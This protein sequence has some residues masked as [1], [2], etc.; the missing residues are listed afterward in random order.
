MALRRASSFTRAPIISELRAAGGA[1]AQSG[2]WDW[3]FLRVATWA[4][5]LGGG[6][7]VAS[8]DYPGDSKGDHALRGVQTRVREAYEFLVL[9]GAP[10]PSKTS[11]S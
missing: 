1:T 4:A 2:P 5:T 8:A 6:L 3:R 9:G 7:V 10:P 11:T